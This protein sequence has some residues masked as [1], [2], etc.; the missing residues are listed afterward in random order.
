MLKN[1]LI[2]SWLFFKKHAVALSL[3]ILPIAAPIDILIA[4]YQYFL[5]SEEFVFFEQLT[6]MIIGV[7]AYPIYAG[8]IVFYMASVI[9]G[10][11]IGTKTAW[12]LGVKFWQPYLA[13]LLSSI[14]SL[15]LPYLFSILLFYQDLEITMGKFFQQQCL[16]KFF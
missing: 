6:P 14:I 4:I 3:I 1:L 13:C 10:E 16:Q 11:R 15:F 8:G 7:V 9:M 12:G 2:D 5:T